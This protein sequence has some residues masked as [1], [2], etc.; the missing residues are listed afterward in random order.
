MLVSSAGMMVAF[1]VWTAL[2][3][4]CDAHEAPLLDLEFWDDLYI[5]SLLQPKVSS[6]R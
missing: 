5:L 4:E 6:S 1:V 3:A 2:S